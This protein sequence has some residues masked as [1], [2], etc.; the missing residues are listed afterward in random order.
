MSNKSRNVIWMVAAIYLGFTGGQLLYN[1]LGTDTDKK[2]LF[3]AMSVVFMA[4]AVVLFIYAIRNLWGSI[5]EDNVA[6]TNEEEAAEGAK[7][8]EEALKE[9]ESKENEETDKTEE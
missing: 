6:I 7:E 9:L 2:V 8:A 1:V 4:A 5:Q 3:I